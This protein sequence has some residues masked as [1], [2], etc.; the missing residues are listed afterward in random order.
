MCSG[1]RLHFWPTSMTG[2]FSFDSLWHHQFT[3]PHF[4]NVS[5]MYFHINY[6]QWSI[7]RGKQ[8]KMIFTMAS[9]TVFFSWWRQFDSCHIIWHD[10]GCCD[11][12]WHTG[13]LES[14]QKIS[15]EQADTHTFTGWTK[16]VIIS[17]S[18]LFSQSVIRSRAIW[19]F[20]LHI[21]N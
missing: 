5:P 17:V 15:M 11:T 12:H 20:Q 2:C 19:V 10:C 16:Y 9:L 21:S 18:G 6:A 14:V 13:N 7:I 4:D 1:S 3:T 8:M